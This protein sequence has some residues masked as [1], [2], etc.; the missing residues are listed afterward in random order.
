MAD[1]KTKTIA[2]VDETQDENNHEKK[3]EEKT[4][5]LETEEQAE[6]LNFLKSEPITGS[7]RVANSLFILRNGSSRTSFGSPPSSQCT[8]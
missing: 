2:T 8:S 1:D 6:K 4:E 3:K 5:V 7:W